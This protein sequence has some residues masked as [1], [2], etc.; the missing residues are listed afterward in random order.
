MSGWRRYGVWGI[1]VR[2]N[3]DPIRALARNVLGPRW[4]P[5]TTYDIEGPSDT[6]ARDFFLFSHR[7]I[8]RGGLR[9]WMSIREVY[10]RGIAGMIHA[11][12]IPGVALET[13]LSDA[14]AAL[15]SIGY[16]IA[17]ETNTPPGTKLRPHLRRI[18]RQIEA[19]IGFDLEDWVL[20]IAD[21]Y[22]SIKHADREDPDTLTLLNT[23]R[24]ARLVFRVWVATRLGVNR[25]T[26][27]RNLGFVP[28]SRPYEILQ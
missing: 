6:V 28:M 7:D 11:I 13:A 15:E 4:A 17:R 20:R 18:T 3:D 10:W 9:R 16:E 2:R 27:E 19:D 25:Q 26:I 1:K 23:L 12:D 22:R 21:I 24:E 5:V 8:E 14:S